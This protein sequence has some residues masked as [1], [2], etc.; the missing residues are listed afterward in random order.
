MNYMVEVFLDEK[1]SVRRTIIHHVQSGQEDTWKSW[2]S[3]RLL[4]F[5]KQR[6]ELR[7]TE[8]IQE[9]E[10]EEV[11][12]AGIKTETAAAA[13]SFETT[14][15]AKTENNREKI[16]SGV[17]HLHQMEIIPEQSGF[18]RRTFNHKQSFNAR[19]FL[20]LADENLSEQRSLYYSVVV[21]ARRVGTMRPQQYIKSQGTIASKNNII[22]NVKWPPLPPEM[23]RISASVKIISK[24][25]NSV[26][27]DEFTASLGGELYKIY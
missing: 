6:P 15:S 10:M 18:P 26:R 12:T 24:D 22:L 27:T 23:Y 19:L 21:I 2:D 8:V 16:S 13:P 7:L 9:A 17:L 11:E 20:D 4:S 3:S 1:N 5:F 14:V 25:K